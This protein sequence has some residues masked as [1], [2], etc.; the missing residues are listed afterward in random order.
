MGGLSKCKALQPRQPQK[1]SSSCIPWAIR[2]IVP[3]VGTKHHLLVQ[4]SP[5]SPGNINISKERAWYP[6]P[7]N[8]SQ[9]PRV[10]DAV[11][12]CALSARGSASEGAS[13][14]RRWRKRGPKRKMAVRLPWRSRL[15]LLPRLALLPP[16]MVI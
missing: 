8:M 3:H 11:C 4:C 1:V 2:T 7:G 5:Y 9:D 16:M 14:L 10:L 15:P 12:V 6:D 13:E